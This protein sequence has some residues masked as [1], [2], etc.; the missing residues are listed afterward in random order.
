M[1]E[2][3]EL[4][5]SLLRLYA[6]EVRPFLEEQQAP[7]LDALDRMASVLE[8]SKARKARLDFGFVGESQVGKS[9]LINAL[10]GQAS[11]PSGGIGPLTAKAT[12]VAHADENSIWVR[13]HT[14]EQLN[15]L[16]FVI[17]SYLIARGDLPLTAT[18]PTESPP[19]AAKPSDD[20]EP[21]ELTENG[22]VNSKKTEK[23][24]YFLQQASLM[25]TGGVAGAD[26][27]PL[28]LLDGLR[29][30]LGQPGKI[31]AEAELGPH[32]GRLAML[33]DKCDRTEILTEKQLGG[34]RPFAK[35]L[36]LRAA[37]ALAP[38][39]A[40]LKV[41][42]NTPFLMYATLVDL[43]GIGIVGD[44]AARV[45]EEFVRTRG[46]ALIIVTRNS[47]LS[48][49][50]SDLLERTGVI[51]KLLF[52]AGDG[53]API[54]VAVAVTHVDS[55]ARE[56]Y[57]EGCRLARETGDAPPDRHQIFRLLA[58]EMRQ[59]IRT[60]VES[61]LRSSPSFEDLPADKKARR[62]D[63][64]T[65]LCSTL[66]VLV[67][68]GNDYL[69][70]TDGQEDL[71]FLKDI[72]VTGVPA[73]QQRVRQLSENRAS[74][75]LEAIDASAQELRS[76][77][78]SHLERIARIYAEGGGRASAEWERFRIELAK[79]LAPLRDQMKAHH[80][81][82]LGILHSTLPTKIELLCK[83]AEALATQKLR[84]LRKRGDAELYFPSLEAALRKDGVWERRAIN[85]PDAITRS[86]VDSVASDW[87][88]TI[89]DGIRQA[90]RTLSEHDIRLVEQLCDQA[91][92]F[93]AKIVAD[94]HI[95][96]QKKLLQQEAK[97][98]VSWTRE[99]LDQFRDDVQQKL[100]EQVKPAIAKAAK[101]ALNAGINRGA[102]AKQRILDAFE[103]G[104]E[105]AITLASARAL[106]VLGEY[107]EC[108]SVDLQSNYLA[109]H[110]DPLQSAFDAMTKDEVT[111]GR[112][113][114][115][116]RR[117]GVLEQVAAILA[118]IAPIKRN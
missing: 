15:R 5:D 98:C 66:D 104:G 111:R 1:S 105:K 71:A 62:D 59:R 18:V 102:G 107:Y 36:R 46:D 4:G 74:R 61:A 53:E 52:G 57:S 13:Y 67:V 10:V 3:D 11:L 73:F 97:A 85:Y 17:Q 94:A 42:L 101:Q 90:M 50:I 16:A 95:D 2:S 44:P 39:V 65:K 23:G 82:I 113:S 26:L 49:T 38:L 92:T 22:S 45:A 89:V 25:I 63:I 35:E 81:E 84:R 19:F 60:Q 69:N 77:I 78:E 9:T 116:Q 48:T 21:V 29:R 70:L 24:E 108:L 8:K 14:R 93:D 112:R 54:Q 118:A 20:D 58:D 68:A 30:V 106:K 83:Q 55:V 86:F 37:G 72:E 76:A 87:E 103:E 32:A 43:P 117:R 12:E 96:M 33:R 75:R 34:P 88:P 27:S 99:R 7:A 40:E 80:G 110:H 41:S 47:G 115:G 114:D 28:A 79:T 91:S 100:I 51:T 56:R 31:W 6:D 109:E 64:V